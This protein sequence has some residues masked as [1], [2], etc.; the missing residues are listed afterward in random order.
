MKLTTY[1]KT[2]LE[3]WV[4]FDDEFEVKVAHLS[5]EELSKIRNS[6]TRTSFNPKSRQKEETVDSDIFVKEFV[7]AAVLDWKGFTLEKATKLLPIEV[8]SDVDLNSEVE[9]SQENALELA[10]N[11]PVFDGWLNDVIFDLEVFRTRGT[12][13]VPG[14]SGEVS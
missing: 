7:K 10:K 3:A 9:Y 1:L 5:R 4:P 6:A 12:K 8:P 11:S 2:K 13:P 14:N